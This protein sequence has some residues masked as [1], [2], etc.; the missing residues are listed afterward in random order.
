MVTRAKPATGTSAVG[1]K[2]VATKTSMSKTPAR[3]AQVRRSAVQA[4]ATAQTPAAA[5][6]AEKPIKALANGKAG[7]TDKTTLKE[8]AKTSDKVKKPKLVRDSFTMPKNEYE[9]IAALKQRAA[10]LGHAPKKS[11]LLRAGIQALM[12]MSDAALMHSLSQVPALKTGRPA[13]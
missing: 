1:K 2:T 11:E 5:V 7:K 13:A 10:R 3:R 6:K 9:A 8:T 4:P 12:A